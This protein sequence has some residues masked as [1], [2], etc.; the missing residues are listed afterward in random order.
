VDHP[1]DDHRIAVQAPLPQA[2]RDLLARLEL[3]EP[4]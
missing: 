4:T 1:G 2:F 3:P